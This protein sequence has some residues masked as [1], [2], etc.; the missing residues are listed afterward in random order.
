[1]AT[2]LIIMD[3]YRAVAHKSL[4]QFFVTIIRNLD[5]D[6][7]FWLLQL[8]LLLSHTASSCRQLYFLYQ[9]LSAFMLTMWIVWVSWFHFFLSSIVNGNI[10]AASTSKK[11]KKDK[12]LLFISFFRWQRGKK[13]FL[14]CDDCQKI[15]N[16]T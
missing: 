15:I 10:C 2:I 4:T 9:Q 14:Y 6:G 3:I 16:R 1:M 5:S 7:L 13:S 11:K 8:S 12:K